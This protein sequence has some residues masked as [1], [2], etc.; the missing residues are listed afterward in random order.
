MKNNIIFVSTLC[1]KKVFEY[2]HR[3]STNKSGQ[4]I[5]KFLE[6]L[7][8]G[9]AIENKN[10]VQTISALPVSFLT[11]KRIFWTFK[12]EQANNIKFN[13]IPSINLPIVKNVI[14]FVYS[15]FKILFLKSSKIGHKNFVI[16]DILKL[17]PTL[18][19]F[20]ACKIRGIKYISILTDM[21]GLSVD[22]FFLDTIKNRIILF[23]IKSHDAYILITEQ[24]NKVVNPLNKPYIIM[25]GLVD[26]K[27]GELNI[28]LEK[29]DDFR[30]LLY[31]GGIY[32]RY[33]VKNLIDAFMKLEFSDIQLHIYGVGEMEKDMVSYEKLDNRIKYKGVISN[34]VLVSKQQK[35][36]ILI[37][38]RP[39][40]EDFTK[41]SFPSKNMEYMVSGIPVLTTHLPG[42]PDEYL[43]Y[44]YLIKD[45]SVNGICEVLINLLNKPKDELY[46][47][48][49]NAKKFVLLNKNN[50]V[51]ANR[52][53]NLLNSL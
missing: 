8:I 39:T 52:I 21:P 3:S 32:E 24:M 16:V 30:V 14:D 11:H 7:T 19:A 4:A 13:F 9:L 53:T 27:M 49:Q 47:F 45:E 20:F 33:G 22:S 26:E 34:N 28:N 29:K 6:L 1:S 35:S 50:I 10:E 12:K 15:F 42:M 37:N 40:I 5:Q 43:S 46:D 2:I 51:Q 41:Y 48:G 18:G 36:T 31:S 25:E 38:P 44:V 17:S 23:F